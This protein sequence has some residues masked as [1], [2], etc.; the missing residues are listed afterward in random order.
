MFLTLAI[1]LIPFA[2]ATLG[3]MDI[4]E[5]VKQFRATGVTAFMTDP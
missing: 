4:E 1:F 2:T 3:V 5:P